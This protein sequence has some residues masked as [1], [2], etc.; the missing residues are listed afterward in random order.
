MHAAMCHTTMKLESITN[1]AGA[2]QNCWKVT[3]EVS[4]VYKLM[5]CAFCIL[6]RRIGGLSRLLGMCYFSDVRLLG[7]CYFSDVPLPTHFS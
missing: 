5:M 2:K 1:D 6:P 4:S 7:M 3:G